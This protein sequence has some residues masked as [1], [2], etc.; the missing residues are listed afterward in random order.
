MNSSEA[1]QQLKTL[2]FDLDGT[3]VDT[4]PDLAYALNC[5]LEEQGRRPLAF[6][7]L[8]SMVSHGANA[9]IYLGFELTPKDEAFMAIR[10]RLLE[11]YR[12]NI[13]R[14][15]QLF[16]GMQQVLDKIESTGLQWGVVT[17]KPGWLT[18]PLMAALDL[19]QR[20]ACIVSGD[21][22]KHS[23]PHPEPMLLAA[24]MA[25]SKNSECLYIGDA[26][27]DIEAGQRAG[28]R[29]LVAL[30][31]Y[32]GESDNPEQWQASGMVKR[33]IDILRWI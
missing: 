28:M 26:K 3:L 14:E 20:A 22:T 29:T 33:P 30:F 7:L 18:L 11:I 13:A 2:L 23:K 24:T 31:G 5:V 12:K 25:N 27:R 19:E 4:A 8:R 32:L 6:E 21:T 10:D 1:N 17:N 16:E 9:L 15:S